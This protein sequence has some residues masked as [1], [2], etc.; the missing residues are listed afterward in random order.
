[1]PPSTLFFSFSIFIVGYFH[2][3]SNYVNHYRLQGQHPVFSSSFEFCNE[4]ESKIWFENY[5]IPIK[6]PCY[7]KRYL[8]EDEILEDHHT[9]LMSIYYGGMIDYSNFLLLGHHKIFENYTEKEAVLLYQIHFESM[10]KRH[11][12]S[13]ISNIDNANGKELRQKIIEDEQEFYNKSKDLG[14]KEFIQYLQ[15]KEEKSISTD[16]LLISINTYSKISKK[17]NNTI[18]YEDLMY[19]KEKIHNGS[20]S[21]L[22]ANSD[23]KIETEVLTD[24]EVLFAIYK[25]R[26]KVW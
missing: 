1:M 13:N 23:K 9:K 12:I 5:F 19:Y 11:E 6:E 8:K 2:N 20:K 10:K 21:N 17:T 4:N 14:S 16:A 18:N 25:N 26:I 24:P 3:Q 15:D 22:F 7:F